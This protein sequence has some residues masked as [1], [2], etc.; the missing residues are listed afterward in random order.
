MG[1][2]GFVKKDKF[3]KSKKKFVQKFWVHPEKFISSLGDRKLWKEIVIM[4]KKS[5]SVYTQ[6]L[7]S[8][9]GV[10]I[11]VVNFTWKSINIDKER[12]TLNLHF[13]H[14]DTLSSLSF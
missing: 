10:A 2:F 1:S 9:I 8:L 4:M 7:L 13:A 6:F 12:K 5:K 14:T 3:K 11:K